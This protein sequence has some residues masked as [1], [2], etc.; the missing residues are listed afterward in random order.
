MPKRS[1]RRLAGWLAIELL[2]AFIAPAADFAYR[3]G[4]ATSR[5]ARVLV[6]ED[7]RHHPAV[8]VNVAFSAPLAVSDQIAA[9][10]AKTHALDRAALLVH[11]TM[12][13]PAAPEEAVM[14]LDTAWSALEPAQV[15]FGDGVLAASTSAGCAVIS[16]AAVIAD[17]AQAAGEPI[18]GLI[19]SAFRV[20]ELTRGLPV[21]ATA[22]RYATV[23]A[24]AL[25]P[26][27]LVSAPAN[28][29]VP[30][31]AQIVAALPAVDPDA[32]VAAALANVLARVRR[33]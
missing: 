5:Q 30:A 16:A 21:R 25:G 10:A 9:A 7:S 1:W 32:R 28:F 20:V 19:R 26:V 29:V 17:C 22:A 14:A 12:E 8:I 24:I 18:R 15:R 33:R 11:S 13:G 2:S 4:A 3:A 31:S 23:Q 6:L 27:V